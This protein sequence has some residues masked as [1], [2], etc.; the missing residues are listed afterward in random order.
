MTHSIST[1]LRF[2]P[3]SGLT[4]RADFEGG[5]LSSDL[6]PLLLRGVDRQLGLIDRL[7]ASIHD[8]R[9]ASYVDH[10]LPDL[11][12]QRIYQIACGYEDGNDANHLRSDPLFK[13]GVGRSPLD[14]DN[15]LA[16]AS[17]L[18][19][20]ENALT[21]RDIYRMA[22]VFID[23]FVNSYATPPDVIVLDM[24]H[25]VDETHGQQAFSFYNHHYRHHCYLPLFIF[26]GISGRFITAVLRNGKT[27]TGA[28]NA[29]IMKRVMQQLRDYWPDTH[30][31]LRGDG[32]FS[33]PE[34][35]QLCVE[36]PH[37]DF[38]FGV[39]NNQVLKRLAAP[40]LEQT[41]H[42][43]QVRCANAQLTGQT[44][45]MHTRTY[46]ELDYRAGSWPEGDL[47]VILKSE[48]MTLGDNPRFVVTSLAEP[49][50]ACVYRDLYAARGQDENYIKAMKLDL[51]SDRTSCSDFLANHVRLYLACAAYILHH[52]LRTE[53]LCHTELAKAQPMTV[54]L[55]LFKLAVKVVQYKDRVKL[56]LPSHY[57]LQLL[58]RQITERLFLPK[59]APP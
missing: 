53:V 28:E 24:D 18:S 41:R 49:A 32:H 14:E 17:T 1:P 21:S 46:R 16:S 26:E 8:A 4:V 48:V 52:S 40:H 51:A 27:P 42:S 44:V 30:F 13:L 29:M 34:L 20:L 2:P 10:P 47:R 57:P 5:A 25:S 38:I 3:V 43:H 7:S 31:I 50:P 56:H 9:H 36:D 54:I 35:M 45:P 37:S 39:A 33:N 11:L 12:A 58:M 23:V 6:G 19:R 22:Q 59:P 55:K 15:H